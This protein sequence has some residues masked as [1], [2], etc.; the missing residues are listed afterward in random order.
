MQEI[1][2]HADCHM[3]ARLAEMPANRHSSSVYKFEMA[4]SGLFRRIMLTLPFPLNPV[5]RR[6]HQ[7]DVMILL[8]FLLFVIV[9]QAVQLAVST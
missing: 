2:N 5:S 1:L 3:T 8:S 6:Q 9:V 4:E 7:Y